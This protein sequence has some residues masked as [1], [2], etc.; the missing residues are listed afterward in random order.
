MMAQLSFFGVAPCL[1]FFLGWGQPMFVD[2][3]AKKKAG[4]EKQNTSKKTRA[5]RAHIG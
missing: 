2:F 4:N 5:V 3:S 1:P